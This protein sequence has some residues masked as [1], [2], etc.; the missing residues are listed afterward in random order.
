VTSNED[1][2]G[3][4]GAPVT[5]ENERSRARIVDARIG[6]LSLAMLGAVQTALLTTAGAPTVSAFLT[7]L[8]WIVTTLVPGV[9]LWSL[10]VPRSD[11]LDRVGF[12]SVAG[13]ALSLL[14]WSV[15]VV[16]QAWWLGWV[17]PLVA[18]AT[19]WLVPWSRRQI[20]RASM[21]RF[22]AR[23]RMLATSAAALATLLVLF[24]THL[25]RQPLPPAANST[26]QD[27]WYHT[28]LVNELSQTAL[29]S[30]PSVAGE[31]LT[32]HWFAHAHMALLSE[33]AG[34]EHAQMVL[35]G[36]Y[37]LMAPTLIA[38]AMSGVRALAP[39]AL[40]W[41]TAAGVFTLIALPGTLAADSTVAAEPIFTV[42]SPTNV[43]AVLVPLALVGAV[44]PLLREGAHSAWIGALPLIALGAGAKPSVLPVVIAGG[45]V[46]MIGACLLQRRILV[47]PTLVVLIPAVAL[48]I[49][50]TGLIGSAGATK[51]QLFQSLTL[52]DAFAAVG[53]IAFRNWHYNDGGLIPSFISSGWGGLFVVA[54]VTGLTSVLGNAT[55][56]LG[57]FGLAS[58]E[59]RRDLAWLWAAGTVAA[60][61][62]A[63]WVLAHPGYS[64]L[65]FWFGVAPLGAVLSLA[66][67]QR[68][69][70]TL[71]VPLRPPRGWLLAGFAVVTGFASLG[72]AMLP[73]AE[74]WRSTAVVQAAPLVLLVVAGC[75]SII[76]LRLRAD[77][78]L[79][80]AV[81]FAII[82]SLPFSL[83][84]VREIITEPNSHQNPQDW[85][86]VTRDE[87]EAALWLREHSRQD[88]IVATNVMCQPV[89]YAEGCSH[90]S[91]WV[92]A[93]SE[94]TMLLSGW[95]YSNASTEAFTRGGE[96]ASQ[97]SPWPDRVRV[98]LDAVI[99]GSQ[100]AYRSLV[101][102][103]G[104]SWYFADRRAT[105][106]ELPP[107]AVAR[108]A[109]ANDEVLIF[110]LSK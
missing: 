46:A 58:H 107:A 72:L 101:E 104:V 76:V 90:Q 7:V 1:R 85:R 31:A 106:V 25:L 6:V 2:T 36:W 47:Q 56:L 51:L 23:S 13:I 5:R 42:L 27:F 39:A 71:D 9:L 35:H 70:N 22:D 91:F 79:A 44:A 37:V 45:A 102:D 49:S 33:L 26:Y 53:G 108:L 74:E 3:E 92:S 105:D 41:I 87:Q 66:A 64:Q 8:A 73:L 29:P 40:P 67:L 28:T 57:L 97:S 96:Y 83:Q 19:M 86:H 50:A 60:G 38:V 34:A 80:A 78:R 61:F 75:V 55:R 52:S 82:A 103:Y 99:S 88:E 63:Q 11:W 32:Y 20:A 110:E 95:A 24:V 54:A 93:L 30:D 98:Q 84:W 62:G 21:V 10:A 68:A 43:L 4:R 14:A 81:C 12:G 89:A 100:E 65:Y 77:V 15:C 16:T 18:C 109:F 94:R 48:A 59:T 17:L 69:F